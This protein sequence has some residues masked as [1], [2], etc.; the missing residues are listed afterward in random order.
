MKIRAFSRPSDGLGPRAAPT[1][2]DNIKPDLYV[3]YIH[4][5][6]PLI[7]VHLY[8]HYILVCRKSIE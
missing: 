7:L 3:I 8:S 5:P 1:D 4:V 2:C 6:L